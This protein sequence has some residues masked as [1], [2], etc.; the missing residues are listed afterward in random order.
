MADPE[1]AAAGYQ[2]AVR[3]AYWEAKDLGAVVSLAAAGYAHCV[4]AAATAGTEAAYRLGS[5]AKALMYDLASFTWP[6]WGEPGVAVLER[7]LEIGFEAAV[8]NLRL[9]RELDKGDL[10]LS[11]A[12]WML[13]G[14]LLASG[15]LAAAGEHFATG[16]T[17]AEAA[18]S[19][20][21]ARLGEAFV[22]LV[23][24]VGG[25]EHARQSWDEAIA[26]LSADDEGA[27]L[28]EQVVT[29]RQVF[30]PRDS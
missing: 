10:A 27:A 5:E 18:G 22:A 24:L 13:G 9:A 19:P 11:R 28:V 30:Q 23:A 16:A 6:G 2:Q 21:E 7:D 14:H 29:A 17:L 8:T 3:V 20:T 25:E 26:R 1:T 15:R 4:A 12:M